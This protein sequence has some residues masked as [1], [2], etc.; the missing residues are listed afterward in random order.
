MRTRTVSLLGAAFQLLSSLAA[1]ATLVGTTTNPTGISGLVVDGISY[2][3]TFSTKSYNDLFTGAAPP[4]IFATNPNGAF[5][6]ESPLSEFLTSQG[7]IGLDAVPCALRTATCIVF[8]PVSTV[9]SAFGGV[10]TNGA[11]AIWTGSGW[12]NGAGDPGLAVDAPAGY[13][14]CFPNGCNYYLV[15]AVFRPAATHTPKFTVTVLD[16]VSGGTAMTATAINNSTQIVGTVTDASGIQSAAIWNGAIPTVIAAGVSTASDINDSGAVVGANNSSW[17]FVWTPDGTQVLAARQG[18]ATG[19]NEAGRIVGFFSDPRSSLVTSPVQWATAGSAPQPLPLPPKWSNGAIPRSINDSDQVV[20]YAYVSCCAAGP[21]H[22]VRW[23][24]SSFTDLGTLGGPSSQANSINNG[25]YITGWAETGQWAEKGK[26]VQRAALWGP[27]TGAFDLGT[28]GGKNSRASSINLEGDV[29]GTAQVPSGAWHAVLWTHKH[30]VAVD[31]N[32]Q[33][34]A[35][36]HDITLTD[37][38]G[39]NNKC[40]I[41]V[42]GFDNKTGDPESFVLSLTDQSNCN[43]P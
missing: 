18:A 20:G 22:A 19:I 2:D 32:S 6:A 9:T 10:T 38:V 41:V 17:P 37:A 4:P 34:G 3:V 42:N 16:N 21:F 11:F 26:H 39:T 35:V 5:D 25:G 27:T 29:V 40:R 12:A 31:L 8:I 43:Q 13:S 1:A 28:L 30:Y 7:V 15:Y 24:G 36:S 33:I 23:R 14:V